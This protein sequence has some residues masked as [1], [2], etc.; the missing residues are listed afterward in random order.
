MTEA[1]CD[2]ILGARNIDV[3]DDHSGARAQKRGGRPPDARCTARYYHDL[4]GHELRLSS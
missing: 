4:A 3:S 1:G 2:G